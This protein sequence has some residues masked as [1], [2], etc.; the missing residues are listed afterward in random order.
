MVCR[1]IHCSVSVLAVQPIAQPLHYL[2]PPD[3]AATSLSQSKNI[4]MPVYV[5]DWLHTPACFYLAVVG[6]LVNGLAVID[7]YYSLQTYA[8]QHCSQA[9]A[10]LQSLQR[11]SSRVMLTLNDRMTQSSLLELRPPCPPISAESPH[12]C[13][14]RLPFQSQIGFCKARACWHMLAHAHHQLR[15]MARQSADRRVR[16]PRQLQTASNY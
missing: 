3:S 16:L 7:R 10:H 2:R 1:G 12:T 6:T 4:Q 13:T 9:E 15:A 11:K 8:L 14:H 5:K